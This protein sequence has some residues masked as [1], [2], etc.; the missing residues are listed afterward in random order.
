MSLT[1]VELAYDFTA[2]G[3]EHEDY[4]ALALR[5]GKSLWPIHATNQYVTVITGKPKTVR[6]GE[7]NGACTVY[8]Q[9]CQ[10]KSR[11]KDTDD[12]DQ[13][14]RAAMSTKI[15]AKTIIAL[16]WFLRIEATLNKAKAKSLGIKLDIHNFASL[17]DCPNTIEF[18]R[19]YEFKEADVAKFA[20]KLCPKPSLK[21]LRSHTWATWLRENV[22]APYADQKRLMAGAANGKKNIIKQIEKATRKITFYEAANTPLPDDVKFSQRMGRGKLPDDSELGTVRLTG[23]WNK[24]SEPAERKRPVRG[25][26]PLTAGKQAKSGGLPPLQA[27]Q[28]ECAGLPDADHPQNRA[29][30]APGRFTLQNPSICKGKGSQCV[31]MEICGGVAQWSDSVFWDMPIPR[32]P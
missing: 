2:D 5:L 24:A 32:A 8:I 12:L 26:L 18:A 28:C 21:N 14:P 27:C 16:N 23:V 10:K 13:N 4:C 3:F 9:G 30:S 11:H 25:K 1:R 29:E 22:N 19:L 31:R 6:F 20:S 7:K 15:Y 17:L